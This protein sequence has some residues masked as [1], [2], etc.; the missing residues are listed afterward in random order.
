MTE[1]R[2]DSPNRI[3]TNGAYSTGSRFGRS[4]RIGLI[5]ASLAVT[6]G[7]AMPLFA[8]N[9]GGNTTRA[10]AVT[11]KMAAELLDR[12][13]VS[14]K[15][16]DNESSQRLFKRFFES[17]DPAKLYFEQADLNAFQAYETKLDD[18][19]RRGD[20][21]FVNQVYDRYQQRLEQRVAFA[22]RL[23][24]SDFDFTKD[25]SIVSDPDQI[26]WAQTPAEMNERW[27]KRI[28][29]DVLQ[30]TLEDEELK[31]IRERLHKRYSNQKRLQN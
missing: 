11:A 17:L 9:D 25:E 6:A 13:H 26:A 20:L 16:I 30:L 1:S 18:A 28:K 15:S 29:Y 14:G 8:Q 19:V 3:P 23:I 27:R 24:D 10:D 4:W 12:Y 21:T 5:T 7:L 2:S 22:Q 31:D